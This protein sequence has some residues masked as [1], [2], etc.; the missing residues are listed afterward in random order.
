MQEEERVVLH[1][2]GLDDGPSAREL[3]YTSAEGTGVQD[4]SSLSRAQRRKLARQRKRTVAK[5]EQDGVRRDRD[6]PGREDRGTRS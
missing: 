5:G 3:R 6:K 4:E 1:A 2:K